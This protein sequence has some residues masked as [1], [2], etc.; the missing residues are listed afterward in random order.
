MSRLYAA[1][2]AM[3]ARN[4]HRVFGAFNIAR[5]IQQSRKM[6]GQKAYDRRGHNPKINRHTGKPHEHKRE[7]ARNLKRAA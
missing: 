1:L 2:M 7:I 6:G 3:E 5:V 4:S